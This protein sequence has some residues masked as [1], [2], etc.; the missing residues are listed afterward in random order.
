MMRTTVYIATSLDG[1]IAREDG[2][3]DWLPEGDGKED[4]GYGAFFGTVDVLVMGRNTY[5]TVRGFGGWPYGDKPVVVL[6]SRPLGD[7]PPTVSAMS[8]EPEAVIAQLAARGFGH[9]YLD[10]GRTV[11]AFLRAGLVNTLILTRVP[12]LLGSGIPL[13]G[14]LDKDVE[15]R[16]VM[17]Q[18]YASGLVQS[19]Y[20]IMA[21]R[22][23]PAPTTDE[24]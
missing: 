4:Y 12:I 24:A 7:A 18:A 13:F 22:D 1:F 20:E 17:T 8:G 2:R 6:T 15:L 19:R 10:G 23:G 9:V 14:R 3:L 16:H 5:D 11:Q 21:E